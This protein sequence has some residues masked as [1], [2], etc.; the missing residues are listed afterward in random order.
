MK[1][2]LYEPTATDIQMLLQIVSLPGWQVLEKINLRELD[3]MQ[4]E[5]VNV[6]AAQPN[7][8]DVLAARHAEVK[9]GAKFYASVSEKIAGYAARVREADQPNVLPDVTEEMLS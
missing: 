6:D 7:F 2:A 3:L 4:V 5:M 1:H 8:R 9:G